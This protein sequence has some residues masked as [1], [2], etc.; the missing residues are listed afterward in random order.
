MTKASKLKHK[1]SEMMYEFSVMLSREAEPRN[2]SVD[3][4]DLVRSQLSFRM[5][6]FMSWTQV[7]KFNTNA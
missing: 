4:E 2:S 1:L 7:K 3:G 5:D 6:G